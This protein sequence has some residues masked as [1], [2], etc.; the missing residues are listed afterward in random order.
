MFEIL[1]FRRHG[2]CSVET[3]YALLLLLEEKSSDR[4]KC[5]SWL[6]L[7]EEGR[8][9]HENNKRYEFIRFHNTF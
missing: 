1:F 5:E 8:E 4:V 3:M 9:K 2:M 7:L 6:D